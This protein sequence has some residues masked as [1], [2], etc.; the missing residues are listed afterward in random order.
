MAKQ[1]QLF[2][3]LFTQENSKLEFKFAAGGVPT[4]FWETYSAFANTDGGLIV[5]GVK[6]KHNDEPS[7]EGLADPYGMMQDILNVMRGEQKVSVQLLSD[8]NFEVFEQEPGRQ[9]LIVE[10]PRATRDQRPVYV[11]KNPIG[12]AYRRM[13]EGDYV[14]SQ[15]EVHRMFADRSTGEGDGALI[16]GFTM[17]DLD[18]ESIRQYRQLFQNRDP[19][20]QFHRLDT[21]E[22][23]QRIGAL[24]RPRSTGKADVTL[25]G[26]LMFGSEQAL[27]D[28][29]GIPS[30]SVDYREKMS[31]DSMV[32]WTHRICDDGNWNHNLFQCYQRII[33]RLYSHLDEPYQID[34]VGGRIRE[35]EVHLGL[36]EALVNALIHADYRGMGGVVIE[37]YRNRYEFS[38]PGHLLVSMAQLVR[39]GTSEC[40]NKNLQR[41]FQYLGVGD[42]AGS[43]IERIRQSWESAL[44]AS[45][46]LTETTG[47]D[48]V[49]LELPTISTLP[50]EVVS[51]LIARFSE[52]VIRELSPEE[53]TTLVYAEQHGQV[54]NGDLQG[55]LT[56]H[57]ADITTLLKGL[58]N[59]GL[60]ER[61]GERR[62]A[63]YHLPSFP[64]SDSS[65]P[66]SDSSFPH[67]DSSFPQKVPKRLNKVDSVRMILEYCSSGYRTVREIATFLGKTDRHVQERVIAPMVKDGLIVMRH[68]G[69]PNHPQQAY[70]TTA[71]DN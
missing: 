71:H 54:T 69:N 7:I 49:H 14:C 58:L 39:G 65:F 18:T 36:K 30:Y 16:G 33:G 29:R 59:Q 11:G 52:D 4:S 27:H 68:P 67:S 55:M 51:R 32:R 26:L 28:P 10:V 3:R 41:M 22:F 40:R 45:P 57:R 37:K 19:D 6:Q 42:K 34:E 31:T 24:L 23:L 61:D 35:T 1:L 21:E 8:E 64:H 60:L 70:R 12:G 25:A 53:M 56:L 20:H 50:Q 43:G 2:D 9:V 46:R 5:L 13:G 44:W 63:S 47:P 17:S 66:H 48:R 38:N 62:G 15:E